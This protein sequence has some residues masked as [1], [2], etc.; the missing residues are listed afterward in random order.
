[1]TPSQI[2]ALRPHHFLCMLTYVGV[3]YTPEFT[4]NFDGLCDQLNSG[5]QYVKIVEGPDDI[6]AVRKE[7]EP[8][9]HC[10]LFGI[11]KRDQQT[12]VALRPLFP[13]MDLRTGSSF[14]LTHGF[15]AKIRANFSGSRVRWPCKSCPFSELCTDVAASG[16]KDARLTLGLQQNQA[17]H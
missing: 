6:C 17:T 1:M 2:I 16:F 4:A 3:G 9:H 7:G 8:H 5:V 12:L 14:V 13:G 15:V 10:P 11:K